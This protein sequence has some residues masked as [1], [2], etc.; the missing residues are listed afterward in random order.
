MEIV[1]DFMLNFEL[2]VYG[3]GDVFFDFEWCFFEVV[4]IVGGWEVDDNWGMIRRFYG[5]RLNDVD[6]RVV[7]V[8][9]VVFV[10]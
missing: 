10:S 9:E 2:G 7:G 4:N 6:M 5:K 1:E 8:G 3:E